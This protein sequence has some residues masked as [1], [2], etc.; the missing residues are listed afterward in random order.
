MFKFK[1]LNY[2]TDGE[3]ELKIIEKVP[4]NEQKG[5]VPIYKYKI[6]LQGSDK[7]IG[8]VDIRIG[9]NEN[10]YY[11]G[12][13]GYNIDEQYRGNSYA[14]K[15]CKIIKRVAIAHDMNKILITCNPNNIASKKTCVKAGLILKS[16]E[17]LPPHN[18]LYQL[19]D[20]QV[21]IYEWNLNER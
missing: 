8:N 3:I 18:S 9:H 12:N 4:A 21:C 11:G 7:S 10:I 15:A 2:L 17:D 13:I 5:Y 6:T 14:A 19:G 1:E 20:R 16:V